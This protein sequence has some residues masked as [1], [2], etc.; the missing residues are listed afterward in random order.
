MACY[1][2]QSRLFEY[3][4]HAN[5]QVGRSPVH[6]IVIIIAIII[7]Y[8]NDYLMVPALTLQAWPRRLSDVRT[9]LATHPALRIRRRA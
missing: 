6:M 4:H 2:A 8:L 1:S 5:I 9:P 3:R 7:V